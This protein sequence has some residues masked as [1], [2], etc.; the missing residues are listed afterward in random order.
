VSHHDR[1][2][3]A[4]GSGPPTCYLWV[5]ALVAL[6]AGCYDRNAVVEPSE[7]LTLEASP[8]VIPAD[9]FSTSQVTATLNPRS[10]QSLTVAFQ[11]SRGTVS[12]PQTSFDSAGRAVA[13]LQSDTR[14]GVIVVTAEVKR[15]ETI[16]ASRSINITFDTVAAGNV[17]RLSVVTSVL[18]ADGASNTE[19]RA[20]L[21]PGVASR[22]VTFT[23]TDGSFS[24]GEPAVQSIPRTAS[25]DGI[26]RA[27]LYAP[28]AVGSAL[29][30]ATAGGFSAAATVTFAVAPPDALALKVSPLSLPQSDAE[31]AAIVA[32]LSRTSGKVTVNTAVEFSAF[33]DDSGDAF[34]SFADVLRSNASEQATAEF[35]P[36]S[37]APLGP[38]TIRARVPGTTLRKEVKIVITPP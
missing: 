9:G 14:P 32:T 35:I 33:N 38:A 27:I 22:E 31:S 30:T 1:V 16:V 23:T 7:I 17:V 12:V 8:A 2:T 13:V 3:S 4:L 34:G 21:N 18:P 19:V 24:V 5:F 20:E 36:G 10:D 28:Q 15:G 37:S 26:A 6:G 11:A 25:E 29:V